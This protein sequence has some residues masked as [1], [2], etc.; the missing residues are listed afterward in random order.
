[1]RYSPIL[2]LVALA[3]CTAQDEPAPQK[4]PDALAEL[5]LCE[6]DATITPVHY[7]HRWHRENASG[8]VMKCVECH[9]EIAGKPAAFPQRCEA[10]HPGEAEAHAAEDAGEHLPAD[11]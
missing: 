3:A 1:M 4:I 9:H 7:K 8:R 5:V 10:C 6:D 11:I 2:I